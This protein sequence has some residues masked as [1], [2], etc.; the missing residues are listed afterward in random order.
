MKIKQAPAEAL[1]L[2]LKSFQFGNRQDL[3]AT[4][5]L[6]KYKFYTDVVEV[7]LSLA[8]RM[9]G[10]YQESLVFLRAGLQSDRQFEKK[11]KETILGM[12]F[13]MGLMVVLTWVFIVTALNLIDVKVSYFNLFLIFFWQGIGLGTLP[14]LIKHFR[15]KFFGGIGK[16]WKMLY[17][18]NSLAKVPLSRTEVLTSAGVKDLNSINQK[19]LLHLV[20][21]LKQTCQKALQQGGSYEEDVNA[22]MEELRFQEKWH[23]ELFEKRLLVIKLVLL[24]VFFLPSYLAFIFVLLGDLMGQI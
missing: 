24:A 13:Q 20:D 23:F 4:K 12:W 5:V 1:E 11:L 6:P 19:A 22:L 2:W 3:A 10:N 14:M 18:L 8:R 21:K 15:N 7:L 16:M 17:I 9:G